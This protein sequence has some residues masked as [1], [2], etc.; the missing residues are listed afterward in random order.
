MRRA[1]AQG[2]ADGYHR[3]SEAERFE[4]AVREVLADYPAMT[5]ADIA[6][7]V[8]WRLS[9]R[10]L[11]DLVARLRPQYV[12]EL[13]VPAPAAESIRAGELVVVGTLQVGSVMTW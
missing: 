2:S 11:S 10:H 3:D 7:V 12:D 1:L 9:R 6:V 13:D 8:D 5:V 4:L